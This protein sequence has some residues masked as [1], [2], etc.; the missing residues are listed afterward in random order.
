MQTV[1]WTPGMW[2]HFHPEGLDGVHFPEPHQF[3]K[4]V[5]QITLLFA[6]HKSFLSSSGELVER[7]HRNTKTQRVHLI[8]PEQTWKSERYYE[9]GHWELKKTPVKPTGFL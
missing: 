1:A 9:R 2:S 7:R 6:P 4:G 8:K 3:P 5:S